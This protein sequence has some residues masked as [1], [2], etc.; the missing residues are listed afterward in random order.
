M[1]GQEVNTDETIDGTSLPNISEVSSQQTNITENDE[2]DT[3]TKI[4]KNDIELT[5]KSEM[6]TDICDK[7]LALHTKFKTSDID[8]G[9]QLNYQPGPSNIDDYQNVFNASGLIKFNITYIRFRMIQT[10]QFILYV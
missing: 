1:S 6:K 5:N 10:S 2:Q 3:D 8:V 7:I 9:A 4:D